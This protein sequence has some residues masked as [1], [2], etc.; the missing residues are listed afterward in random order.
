MTMVF[1]SC[2]ASAQAGD[3]VTIKPGSSPGTFTGTDKNTG[4][5]THNFISI[6]TSAQENNPITSFTYNGQ[7]CQLYAKQGSA[8]CSTN[9]PPGATATFSGTTQSTTTGFVFCTSDDS[10]L[11]NT[12]NP[13]T[14]SSGGGTTSN[15]PAGLL[16]AFNQ[17][18]KDMAKVE[19]GVL[20]GT[21]SGDPLVAAI[22]NL[23]KEKVRLIGANFSQSLYGVPAWRVI[24]AFDQIDITL[25]KARAAAALGGHHGT[26]VAG[27]YVEGA[28]HIKQ[29]LEK[30]LREAGAPDKVLTAL[31]HF[32]AHMAKV[33]QQILAGKL[34][35]AALVAAIG[36]LAKEK[37]HL[38]GGSFGQSLYGVPAW[39]VI[40]GFD[41][42]DVTLEKARAAAAL[43]GHHNTAV[44][45]G[46]VE[47][48][49]HIKQKLEK[50]FGG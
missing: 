38:I 1:G 29:K 40:V 23:A 48:A 6:G 36:G 39:R 20:A 33:A 2:V 47:G 41:Q 10:G 14:A 44:A 19:Q 25:E 28:I 24:V 30:Q 37:A 16:A 15:V 31:G 34:S 12:C 8:Y 26:A 17:L 32:D 35:G 13:V 42:V 11:D 5:N 3:E 22:G 27:G 46:Y 9:L 49:I 45:G 50:Q 7:Q 43:G 4:A 18:D 21:L